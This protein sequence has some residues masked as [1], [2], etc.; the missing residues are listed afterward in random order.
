MGSSP[1]NLFLKERTYSSLCNWTP[2]GAASLTTQLYFT[3][4]SSWSFSLFNVESPPKKSQI[5]T[6]PFHQQKGDQCYPGIWGIQTAFLTQ[7]NMKWHWSTQEED[8]Q[9]WTRS[10]CFT[11]VKHSHFLPLLSSKILSLKK[12]ARSSQC[13]CHPAH[14]FSYGKAKSYL[15]ISDVQAHMELITV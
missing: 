8:M 2:L 13:K 11:F 1:G 6:P 4:E 9:I 5:L 3:P 15:L 12:V 14:H 7:H 10:T